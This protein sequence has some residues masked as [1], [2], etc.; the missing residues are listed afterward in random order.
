MKL[1]LIIISCFLIS[2]LI[3]SLFTAQFYKS[4]SQKPLSTNSI[5]IMSSTLTSK[6]SV[7][8][9]TASSS[10]IK[11]NSSTSKTLEVAV[12]SSKSNVNDSCK[13]EHSLYD[14][15]VEFEDF[16]FLGR[17]WDYNEGV[18]LKDPNRESIFAL[19]KL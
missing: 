17:S 11:S 16:C 10:S 13:Y 12:T 8:F 4:D 15:E 1:K 18:T 9:S 14:V 19:Q 5:V 2:T 3:G 6:E 7:Q